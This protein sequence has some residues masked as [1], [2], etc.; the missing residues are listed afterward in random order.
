MSHVTPAALLSLALLASPAPAQLFKK[1]GRIVTAPVRVPVNTAKQVVR[2]VTG[3]QS[4][5]RGLRNIAR[6][7]VQPF[8]NMASVGSQGLRTVGRL[9]QRAYNQVVRGAGRIAGRPGRWVADV[10]TIG[11]RTM[12]QL[13]VSTARAGLQVAQGRN[14]LRLV[15][16]PL[17][18]AIRSA[19]AQHRRQARPI[20]SRIRNSL[21]RIFSRRVLD[22]ARYV[23]GDPRLTLPVGINF[24]QGGGHAVVVDNII[25]FGRNPGWNLRWWAHEMMHVEQYM[26]WGV[27]GFA[28]NYL[29]NF[30]GVENEAHRRAARLTPSRS[31]RSIPSPRSVS[32]S[33]RSVL[34]RAPTR[35]GARANSSSARAR[36]YSQ[37]RYVPYRVRSSSVPTR[38][39][40][41]PYQPPRFV[42]RRAVPRART[43]VLIRR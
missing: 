8:R 4:V 19:H 13:G 25:V 11:P 20:P 18:A 3:K 26:R 10:A 24:M 38:T 32:S 34:R 17:A 2:T 5:G 28:L 1:I 37:S 35:A 39:R 31:T 42:P 22:R 36:S 40:Y 29:R 27:D 30:R 12:T 23:V 9:H 7:Q 6:T 14:P 16:A 33:R 21:A 41:V 43:Q 15:S